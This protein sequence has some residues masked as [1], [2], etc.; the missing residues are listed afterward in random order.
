MAFF[1]FSR[2]GPAL[3][4]VSSGLGELQ[5]GALKEKQSKL[6][7]LEGLMNYQRAAEL[8]GRAPLEREQLRLGNESTAQAIGQKGEL[9]P[10]Q[11]RAAEV[12]SEIS[13]FE[14]DIKGEEA[15]NAPVIG[16]LNIRKGYQNLKEGETNIRAKEKDIQKTDQEILYW[17]EKVKNAPDDR[18]ASQAETALKQA[19][20]R[21][22]DAYA[23]ALGDKGENAAEYGVANNS[24]KRMT[25]LTNNFNRLAAYDVAKQA[26]VPGG[27]SGYKSLMQNTLQG[28][29]AQYKAYKSAEKA[30]PE[31]A[32]K[33]G[34]ALAIAEELKGTV[35]SLGLMMPSEFSDIIPASDLI[36]RMQGPGIRPQISVNGSKAQEIVSELKAKK[37]TPAQIG[38][39]MNRSFVLEK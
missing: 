14:R 29:A 1:D 4:G 33:A 17:Q 9:F 15:L 27:T 35:D 7:T 28:I 6:N 22:E 3:L 36:A 12:Q 10:I 38:A 25:A 39:F 23:K 21:R 24:F 34:D 16:N 32:R 11:K 26:M 13:G 19:Q 8:L 30:N 37:L 5:A 20:A 2:L 31:M 18:A